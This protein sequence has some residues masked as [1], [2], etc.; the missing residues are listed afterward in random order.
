MTEMAELNRLDSRTEAVDDLDGGEARDAARL[1]RLVWAAQAGD[2]RARERLVSAYLDLVRA[3]ASR[4]RTF[5]IPLDDLVQEGSIG[6]L[7]AIDGFDAR[8]SPDFERYARFRVRRAINNALTDQSRLVRLPK[9]VVERRRAID[10]AGA[11]LEAAAGRA[12]TTDELAA[13]TGLSPA[14][15]ADARSAAVELVSLDESVSPDGSTLA[16]VIAD[17]TA[18]DPQHELIER[19]RL[20]QLRSEVDALPP[21]QRTMVVRHWGLDGKPATTQ[22]LAV[23]LR[24]SPGRARTIANDALYALRDALDQPPPRARRKAA[25]TRRRASRVASAPGRA[26]A[27]RTGAARRGRSR[28]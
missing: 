20:E 2:R 17:Q 9:H 6:L 28:R 19:E 10:R 7:E 12:A 25:I 24:L 14:A 21:R 16:T 23:E 27:P 11:T 13:T 8:K 15:I 26:A 22:D 4:Y 1:R 3:T 5:G 18:R